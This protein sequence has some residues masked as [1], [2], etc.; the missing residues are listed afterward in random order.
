MLYEVITLNLMRNAAE[1]L[2][3]GRRLSI[4]APGTLIA[5]G[6]RSLEIRISYNFV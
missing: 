5:D 1:A 6:V 2:P 3:Q 4:T